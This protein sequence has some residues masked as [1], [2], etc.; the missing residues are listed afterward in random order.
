MPF[1]TA[2]GLTRQWVE[3]FLTEE[4]NRDKNPTTETAGLILSPQWGMPMSTSQHSQV[5]IVPGIC[6]REP[7][8][9]DPVYKPTIG[10][11]AVAEMLDCSAEHCR[12]LAEAKPTTVKGSET[13][14]PTSG[15]QFQ[16][17]G[18]TPHRGARLGYLSTP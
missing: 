2:L 4:E 12:R 7:D 16:P 8:R 13:E 14:R 17:L 1:G 10:L 11:K 18:K 6:R 3:T 15:N 5:S 9:P